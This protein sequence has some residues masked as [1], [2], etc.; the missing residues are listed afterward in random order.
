MATYFQLPSLPSWSGI[1]S[2]IAAPLNYMPT[3]SGMASTAASATNYV[4]SYL[5]QKNT[6]DVQR[7]TRSIEALNATDIVDR[8]VVSERQA[9]KDKKL[10][11]EERY[12]EICGKFFEDPTSEIHKTWLNF[13]AEE[14]KLPSGKTF[15]PTSTICTDPDLQATFE[16]FQEFLTLENERQGIVAEIEKIGSAVNSDPTMKSEFVQMKREIDETLHSLSGDYYE[17]PNCELDKLWKAYRAKVDDKAPAEEVETAF[18]LFLLKDEMRK[19]FEHLQFMVDKL[20]FSPETEETNIQKT[21][22]T[23]V[24]KQKE[25]FTQALHDAEANKGV[26]WKSLALSTLQ[27]GALAGTYI[28]LDSGLVM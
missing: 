16:A 18:S 12:N 27:V 5:P 22:A 4:A 20:L 9:L 3:L 13:K 2:T 24:E 19:A 26:D 8:T 14:A 17:D 28:V 1:K 7:L 23:K 15:D 25:V 10:E 6:A 21:A 11:L